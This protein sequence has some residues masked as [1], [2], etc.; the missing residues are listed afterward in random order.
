M[1]LTLLSR[2]LSFENSKRCLVWWK[3]GYIKRRQ[4]IT[5]NYITDVFC[6]NTKTREREGIWNTIKEVNQN[7]GQIIDI[8]FTHLC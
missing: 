8:C 5:N 4:N 2:A 1:L 3:R 6:S 7:A